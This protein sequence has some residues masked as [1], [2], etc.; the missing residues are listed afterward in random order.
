MLFRSA[1]ALAGIVSEEELS[2]EYIIP[3]ALNKEVAVKVAEA[4][5]RTAVDAA[6]QQD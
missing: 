6:K 5:A 3:N 4:V 2:P 1:Y